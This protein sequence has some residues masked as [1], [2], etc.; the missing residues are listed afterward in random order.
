MLGTAQVLQCDRTGA[1]CKSCACISV[2]SAV[3]QLLT[4]TAG[5]CCGACW[6][7][8]AAETAKCMGGNTQ[9]VGVVAQARGGCLAAASHAV[10][11]WKLL[12]RLLL[13]PQPVTQ[14]ESVV[15]F[16]RPA[17]CWV[18]PVWVVHRPGLA[19]AQ[20]VPWCCTFTLLVPAGCFVC[21]GRVCNYLPLLSG[22]CPLVPHSHADA[23]IHA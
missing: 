7:S 17:G 11:C 15:L 13:V 2:M 5:S 12:L 16:C 19:T 8:W 21:S 14:V 3:Q 18:A 4:C 6:D 1:R 23:R 9:S 20:S 10:D 22:P